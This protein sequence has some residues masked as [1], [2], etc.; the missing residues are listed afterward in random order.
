MDAYDPDAEVDG[1]YVVAFVESAG[2]VS[3]VFERKVRRILESH[4]DEIDPSTW[5]RTGDLETAYQEIHEEIGPKTMEEG[6]KEVGKAI[7]WP[8]GVESVVDG[9]QTLNDV[10]K[11]VYRNSPE[12][13]PAG[14]YTLDVHGNGSVRVG[15]TPGY[16]YTPA[17]ARGVFRGIVTDLGGSSANFDQVDARPEEAAAWELEW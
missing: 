12:E 7:P 11:S 16:Q 15:I 13:F 1:E 6:G 14:K 8:D 17:F 9:L 10:H 2:K 3:P 4:V 5:Y